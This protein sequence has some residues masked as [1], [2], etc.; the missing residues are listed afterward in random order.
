MPS[1]TPRPQVPA[2]TPLIDPSRVPVAPSMR[3]SVGHVLDG[4][5]RLD[6]L[7]GEGGMGAVHRATQLA[8]NRPVAVKV[9]KQVTGLASDQLS[10]R[11]KREAIATSRLKHPNTVQLIDFGESDGV[12]YLV[13]ELL[14]GEPLS[15]LIEREAPLSLDRVAAIGKQISKSLAEAHELGIVHRDLK[16]DNVFICQYAGDKDVPKVMDFGIA[17]VMTSDV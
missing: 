17:R 12:L 14:D 16:P 2:H 11:F 8:V 5:Y 10:E 9:L 1:S 3:L 4:K 15:T 13:L 7:I 6:G